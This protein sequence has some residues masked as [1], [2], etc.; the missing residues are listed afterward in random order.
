MKWKQ[1]N[2]NSGHKK[3][4]VSLL[5]KMLTVILIPLILILTIVVVSLNS[6]VGRIVFQLDGQYA[7]ASAREAAGSVD[8]FFQ[9]YLAYTQTVASSGEIQQIADGW[10]EADFIGSDQ[11]KLLTSRLSAFQSNEDDTIKST[12]VYHI[13]TAQLVQSD[14]YVFTRDTFDATSREWYQQVTEKKTV[15]VSGAYE[16][17]ATGD[18]VVTVLAPMMRGSTMQA[19][20]GVDISISELSEMLS[21][22]T[23]GQSG[24]VV[25]FD[26]TSQCVYHPQSEYVMKH[27]DEVGYSQELTNAVNNKQTVENIAIERNGADLYVTT[28]FLDGSNF[29]VLGA[30]SPEEFQVYLDQVSMLMVG[31]IG[32]CVVLLLVI[33]TVLGIRLTRGVK[34]LTAVAGK[35][36]DGQ[37][38]VEIKTKSNDE[39]GLLADDIRAIV[40]RL[41]EYIV[42]IDEITGTLDKIG[43]GNFQFELKHDYVG[44]FAKIKTALMQ[45]KATFSQTLRSVIAAA[46]QVDNGANQLSAGAQNLAQGSTEQASSIE[47]LAASINEIMHHIHDNTVAT[48]DSNRDTKQVVKDLSSGSEKMTTM[49]QAMDEISVN[50]MEVGKIIKSIED[51]AFQTNILALNAAVEAARAGEAGKGFAVVAD[52]VRNLAAKTAQASKSTADLIVKALNAVENGKKVADDTAQTFNHIYDSIQQIA[53]R[54]ETIA[55]S[56]EYQDNVIRQTSVGVD[57]ISNVVQ[58]NTATAEEAAA[59]SEELSAQANMLKELV[60]QFVFDDTTKYT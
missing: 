53:Q 19:I 9:R 31:Y 57:Q 54:Y 30:F 29:M 11:Q 23:I 58:A 18:L 17:A 40:A 55:K 8:S 44:E 12:W 43:D 36:A 51:I 26:S 10:Q 14:G 4:K 50:S 38:D 35:I 7:V 33:V 21:T 3:V 32:A 34:E 41:R 1:S 27:L 42:Y 5:T 37:L 48:E 60:N 28:T 13:K 39:V 20:V 6:A 52:E 59:T 22:V 49:L 16:E 47:Q 56:A 45:V 2:Q 46:Q 24:Y 25:L 15:C